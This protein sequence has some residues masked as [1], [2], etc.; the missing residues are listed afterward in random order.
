MLSPAQIEH[1]HREGY[2]IPD[3]RLPLPVLDAIKA[4][5]ARLIARHPEFADYCGALLV[6]D[7]CFLNYAN[8]P[9][10]LDMVAQ[11]IGPDIALWNSSMFAKPAQVGTRTPWHQDGE[12]WPIEPLATCTVWI[13]L[14]DATPANGCLRFL[15]GTHK[16]Q[17]LASHHFSDAKDIALPLE[18]DAEYVD[19]QRAVDVELQAGQ[20][21]LH[22]VYLYHGSAANPTD[23]PR[24]GMTLRYMPTTS[25]YRRDLNKSPI[26]A[27]RS[28][29]LMRG[30]DVS[31]KND[32]SV[33]APA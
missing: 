15:P 1:Y 32:F 18:L 11:L 21:S 19:E 6:Q 3:Y 4:D 7:F 10:I 25:V 29:F 2:V 23:Q 8:N 13:A 12:Y 14:D 28:V 26:D 33:Q 22:D 5:H 24:R 20:M 27:R 17:Q 16:A 30:R 9:H 31:G